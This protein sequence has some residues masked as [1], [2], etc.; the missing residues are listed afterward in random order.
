MLLFC[1]NT[2]LDSLGIVS[3]VVDGVQVLIV[4]SRVEVVIDLGIVG[5]PQVNNLWLELQNR[6][7]N[8][9]H[10]SCVVRAWKLSRRTEAGP[11]AS[12]V[13]QSVRMI[14]NRRMMELGERWDEVFFLGCL[15]VC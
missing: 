13:A 7:E 12:A 9:Y 8:V 3:E 6:L 11:A 1:V 15:L 14:V 10:A 5:P 4:I 2:A